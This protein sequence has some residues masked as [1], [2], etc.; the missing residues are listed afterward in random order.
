[1]RR[2][3]DP[4]AFAGGDACRAA[5]KLVARAVADFDN[6]ERETGQGM[7]FQDETDATP[8]PPITPNPDDSGSRPKLRVVK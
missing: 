8:P 6:R 7:L 2:A 3:D 5:A 4:A 1:M